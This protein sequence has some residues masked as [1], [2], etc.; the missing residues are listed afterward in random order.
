[1]KRTLLIVS[2][3]I[4]A[5]PGIR[6]ANEM[7]LH[8]VVSDGNPQAPGMSIAADHFVASTYDAEATVAAARQYHNTVRPINGVMCIA[9][10]VPFTVARV[11]EELGLPGISTKSARLTT[12]KMAMKLQFAADGIPIPFFGDVN[13]VTGLRSLIK[14][15]GLPLVLKPVDS[16]G[17]R[18]VLRLTEEVDLVWALAYSRGQSPTGRVMVEKFL[19][20]PQVSTESLVIDGVAYTLGFSDRNYELLER[21]RPH[22]IENGGDLP[23]L[24]AASVKQLV[25]E[26]VGRAA[27]SLGIHNGVVKGD[28]VI[29]GGKPHVIEMAARLSGGYFCTHKIPLNTGVNFVGAAIRQALGEKIDPAELTPR[30]QRPVAQ[31]YIFPRPGRITAIHGVAAARRTPGLA[32]LLVTVNPGSVIRRPTDSNASAGMA[33]ACADTRE[34]AV[35]RAKQAVEA[36]VIETEAA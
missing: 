16:R 23:T 27:A 24:L 17:S 1:M 10:D 5:V 22:I 31:R 3:G 21:Y 35:R 6:L 32:E 34:E 2:G 20:G 4:E 33:V 30:C 26:L 14:T 15:R 8:V 29:F 7:G 28:I 36:V 18:G 19:E 11:A 12:D 9:S 25:H 13:S